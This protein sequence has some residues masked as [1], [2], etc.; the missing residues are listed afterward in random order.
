MRLVVLFL[1]TVS[2]SCWAQEMDQDSNQSTDFSTGP[3]YLMNFPVPEFL[4]QPIATPSLS[5][6]TP[7][8]S[9]PNAAAA[10][11]TGVL[12]PSAYEG[13]RAQTATE[14]F[15]GVPTIPAES[16]AAGRASELG[17]S[18]A[19]PET[20]LG[21]GYFDAGVSRI[22]D[23]PESL[24]PIPLGDVARAAKANRQ[25]VTRVFTNEDIARLDGR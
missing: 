17:V 16:Y 1:L 8:E 21:E 2:I 25:S 23:D 12:N 13:L 15:W 10:Q 14:S 5:L 19:E 6:S 22:V 4:L 20:S 24:R 3:Q 9:N 11:G 18:S 7:P